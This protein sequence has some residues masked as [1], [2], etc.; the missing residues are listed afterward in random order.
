MRKLEARKQLLRNIQKC[1]DC[2]NKII[3]VQS[4][5]IISH[6]DESFTIMY[7]CYHFLQ[8]CRGFLLVAIQAQ[9]IAAEGCRVHA[10]FAW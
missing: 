5:P 8:T 7:S 9:N 2:W 4:F 1:Q 6:G 3:S 10:M